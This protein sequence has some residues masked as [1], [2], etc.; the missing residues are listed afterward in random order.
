MQSLIASE[1]KAMIVNEMERLRTANPYGG[2]ALG[3]ALLQQ[4]MGLQDTD[5]LLHQGGGGVPMMGAPRPAP[6]C[7]PC[8][9]LWLCACE[10]WGCA[11]RVLWL[12]AFE[13]CGCAFRVLWLCAFERWGCARGMYE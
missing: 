10:R 13:R 1:R 9:R 12:C 2:G 4:A 5:V 3:A 11:F 6:A 8:A 7:A